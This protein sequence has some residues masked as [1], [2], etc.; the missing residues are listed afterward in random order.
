MDGS[1][2][3]MWYFRAISREIS[4]SANEMSGLYLAALKVRLPYDSCNN[5]RLEQKINYTQLTQLCT[6]ELQGSN[7]LGILRQVT[8]N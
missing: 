3:Y 6:T 5:K 2:P 4:R 7:A 1:Y 8:K